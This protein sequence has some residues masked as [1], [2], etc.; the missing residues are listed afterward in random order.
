MAP[1]DQGRP[2][3]YPLQDEESRGITDAEREAQR[4]GPAIVIITGTEN[5]SST[6]P[7]KRWG[8]GGA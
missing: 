6:N 7:V 5:R 2:D 3:H 8:R 4:Q 1:S